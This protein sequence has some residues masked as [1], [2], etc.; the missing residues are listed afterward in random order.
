MR[1]A[2]LFRT[3]LPTILF[4]FVATQTYGV[5]AV[6]NPVGVIQKTALGDSDT[7]L[8]IPLK[9]PAEFNG[10]V[11]G[12]PA[13]STVTA[14][15]SPGWT[16]D[17]WAGGGYYAFLRSGAAAGN[18]ATITANDADSLT[19]DVEDLIDVVDG[20]SFSIHPYWTLGLLFPGGDGVNPSTS[21]V[22]RDSEIF[23]PDSSS[24][25]INLAA[26]STFYYYD[27]AFRRV[28]AAL[29]SVHDDTILYPDSY[30]ILRNNTSSS[31]TVT[32]TGEVVMGDL[33]LPILFQDD[34]Q[35]DNIVGLQRPIE[36]S[37]DESGLAS[38]GA[39]EAGDELLVWDDTVAA[40]NRLASTATVYTWSGAIWQINNAGDDV[41][42]D[43]VFTPGKGFIIRKADGSEISDVD[44][45]NSPNYGN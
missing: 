33:G 3:L 4:G 27:G 16:A 9:L 45:L 25:G 12:A 32:F 13:G 34:G 10:V 28:G 19:L 26:E 44:W 15:G 22:E 6:T 18:Y 2:N 31:T 24:I 43:L 21:H 1:L 8:S 40:K 14:A 11:S 29:D 17:E 23:M 20:N 35:Q 42:S 30:F 37:L 7:A 41:G 5:E 36:M 38:S 39:F